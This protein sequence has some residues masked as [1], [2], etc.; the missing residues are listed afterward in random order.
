M[1]LIEPERREQK[2]DMRAR[3]ADA[4]RTGRILMA[5]HFGQRFF[6][7]GK[8]TPDFM[9]LGNRK[10]ESKSFDVSGVSITN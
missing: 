7:D 2:R 10:K 1:K 8:G 6:E 4:E 3:E 9:T 5:N